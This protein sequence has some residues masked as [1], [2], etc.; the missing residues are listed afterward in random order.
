MTPQPK[1]PGASKSPGTIKLILI[2]VAVLV[3]F[4]MSA[5]ILVSVAGD[6]VALVKP[7]LKKP[8]IRARSLAYKTDKD[9]AYA[10]QVFHDA[11]Q[12]TKTYQPYTAWRQNPI[13][14][15]TLTLNKDGYRIHKQSKKNKPGALKIGFFGGSTMWGTGVDDNNTIPAFFDELTDNYDVL[16]YG[17]RG[18]T[19]RQEL[20]LLINLINQKKA[21]DIVV[22]YDGFNDLW[23]HCNYAITTSLNSHQEE[24]TLRKL[25]SNASTQSALYANLVQPF[26]NFFQSLAKK[27]VQADKLACSTD[28]K[29][30]QA[31][32][33][34]MLANWTMARQLVTGYG[35]KFYGFLQPQLYSGSPRSDYVVLK[36]KQR[37][38][39]TEFKAVY[40]LLQRQISQI[41]GQWAY[42]FSGAFDGNQPIYVDDVHV[43]PA[44]NRIIA[45]KI[46]NI[47]LEKEKTAKENN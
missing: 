16:N 29:R 38:R 2:N 34:M 22:F 28:P 47:V 8:D 24:P 20:A 1:D 39:G 27:R 44:G 7:L 6:I 25:V 41:K 35:G 42:D 14:L 45:E 23:I 36:K 17:E 19:S 43:A 30:A 9:K 15:P 31:V 5:L 21:P 11:R 37:G 3:A 33:D 18:Y 26:V 10:E 46:R 4:V 40:P 13:S 32:A 12:G